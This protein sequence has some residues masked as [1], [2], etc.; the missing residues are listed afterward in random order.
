M[1]TIARARKASNVAAHSFPRLWNIATIN[2]GMAAPAP[3]RTTVLAES[4]DATQVWN[5]SKV[6]VSS[7][8]HGRAYV[9][10]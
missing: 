1:L 2:S 7:I 6:I 3:L 9:R 8:M 4:A 5:L 10:M